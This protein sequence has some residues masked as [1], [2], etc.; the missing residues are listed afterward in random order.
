M[1]I[2]DIYTELPRMGSGAVRRELPKQAIAGLFDSMRQAYEVAGL[3]VS[4]RSR[5]PS[6][7]LRPGFEQD[8]DTF[9]LS[10]SERNPTQ[11]AIGRLAAA[12]PQDSPIVE[13]IVEAQYGQYIGSR[14]VE[15]ESPYASLTELAFTRNGGGS[16]ELL[17]HFIMEMNQKGLFVP[18][19]PRQP[20]IY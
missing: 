13:G 12:G 2:R 14:L 19:E 3:E 7:R 6:R 11:Y 20:V 9:Q 5:R 16:L 17:T 10:L 18:V 4:L 15:C 1:T 8:G